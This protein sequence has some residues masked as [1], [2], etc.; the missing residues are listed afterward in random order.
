MEKPPR[1]GLWKFENASSPYVIEIAAWPL[2]A[3]RNPA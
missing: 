3:R 1:G 2:L